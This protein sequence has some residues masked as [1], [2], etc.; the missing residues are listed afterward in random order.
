MSYIDLLIASVVVVLLPVGAIGS[1]QDL[2]VQ[3]DGLES[4]VLGDAG[5]TGVLFPFPG[6]TL[7]LSAAHGLTHSLHHLAEST[8]APDV[9][10]KQQQMVTFYFCSLKM[11]FVHST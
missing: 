5:C 7:L 6:H 4:M 8:S 9:R 10:Y 11:D 2:L 3:T 1:L